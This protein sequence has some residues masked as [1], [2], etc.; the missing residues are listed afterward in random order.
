MGT[1]YL[2][3]AELDGDTFTYTGNQFGVLLIHGFT[4]T[5]TEVRLLADIFSDAGYT[6]HAPLLPGHGVTPT[7]LN[8]TSF[9]QWIDEVEKAYHFIKS[10]CPTV[11]VGGESMGA[12]LSLHMAAIHPEVIGVLCYSP[13]ISV[14]N[15]WISMVLRYL[16]QEIKK[17][18]PEGDLKWKGYK[19]NP[20]RASAEMYQLQGLVRSELLQIHQPISIYIGGQDSRISKDAG[21]YILKNVSSKTKE[22]NFYPES[23]HCMILAQDL[24]EIASRSLRFISSISN[25]SEIG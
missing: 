12:L 24:P 1:E 2:V 25:M 20:V 21:F 17:T 23:P 22:L 9:Q 14:K 18:R 3:R 10:I 19:V 6:I 16:I 4:A 15:L 11:L 8:N 5:T 7:E 13:A